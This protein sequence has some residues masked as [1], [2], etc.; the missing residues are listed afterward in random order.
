MLY[1]I[2]KKI[3]TLPIVLYRTFISPFTPAACRYK[4]TCSA[5][6]LEAIMKWGIFK[7]T[8]LGIKRILRCHPWSKHD[9]FDPVPERKKK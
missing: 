8:W 1:H 5:Y 3:F 9:H 2:I 6:M 7:G 4:P